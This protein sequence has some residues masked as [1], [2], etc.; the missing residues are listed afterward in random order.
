M[1]P[2]NELDS[3]H[4]IACMIFKALSSQ[5]DKFTS[6]HIDLTLLT[7]Q[8]IGEIQVLLSFTLDFLNQHSDDI[9]DFEI[10]RES[11]N[12]KDEYPSIYK[13]LDEI[14]NLIQQCIASRLL[15]ELDKPLIAQL[16]RFVSIT[17]DIQRHIFQY[18]DL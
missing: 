14:C 16:H 7:E 18:S 9:K 13:K 8:D 4:S 2:K 5:W 17:F 6:D 15:S 3:K 10:A 12:C 1:S 11:L